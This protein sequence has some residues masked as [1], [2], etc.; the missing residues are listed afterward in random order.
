[1]KRHLLKHIRLIMAKTIPACRAQ[2]D[3]VSLVTGG[4]HPKLVLEGHGSRRTKSLCS[5][6]HCCD[7]AVNLSLRDI[8]RILAEMAAPSPARRSMP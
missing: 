3:S 1:M 8:R 2:G 6:P 5:T 7:A 4:R